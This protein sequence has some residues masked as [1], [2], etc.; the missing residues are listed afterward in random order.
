MG[1]VFPSVKAASK[2]HPAPG[3]KKVGIPRAFYYYSY[4][5]LW[6]TY[7]EELG[8]I[9]VV[10]GRSTFTTIREATVISESE[11]CLP[12]KL[13]DGHLASLLGKVDAMFIPRVIS[14]T[15]GH[16]ACP[17]FGALPDAARASITGDLEVITFDI[18]ENA[19]PLRKTMTRH[20][21][22]MGFSSGDARAAVSRAFTVLAEREA[23]ERARAVIEGS[24]ERFLLLGHPYTISDAYIADP[25]YRKLRAMGVTV[26]KMT[27]DNK[28]IEPGHLMWCTFNKMWA[29]LSEIS[30][31]EYAGVIQ[32]TTFNCGADTM[33]LEKF[34]HLAAGRGIPY[35]VLMTDEHTAQAGVDTRLEAFVD[36]LAWRRKERTGDGAP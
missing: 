25:V 27:F 36:S 35:M 33:M 29:K 19:R 16:I 10:S 20:A 13:F 23:A 21:K 14:M 22:S 18:N 11:H 3:A 7:F 34:R 28:D 2:N 12:N 31:S 1:V 32:L 17:K 8:M 24:G 5:G 4:P 9:P 30:P 26:E 15:K 6:E